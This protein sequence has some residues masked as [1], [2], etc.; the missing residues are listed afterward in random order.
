MKSKIDKVYAAL[1]SFKIIKTEEQVDFF[2]L[3]HCEGTVQRV[4]FAI[5]LNNLKI[6]DVDPA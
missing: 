3:K 2:V 5:W 4:R 1:V 6:S